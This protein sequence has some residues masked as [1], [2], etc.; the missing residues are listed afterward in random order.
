VKRDTCAA[1]CKHVM[2]RGSVSSGHAS[3]GCRRGRDYSSLASPRLAACRAPR[4]EARWVLGGIFPRARRDER[5][6]RRRYG[7]VIVDKY[8]A[9]RRHTKIPPSLFSRT[10]APGRAM[11]PRV[12]QVPRGSRGDN[13]D[14][15]AL[16]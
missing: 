10:R 15:R 5:R 9:A 4:G 13:S 12:L 6:R 2:S 14:L 11:R 1:R 8:R 3:G 7:M 16:W